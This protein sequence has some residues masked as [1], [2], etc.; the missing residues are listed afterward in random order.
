MGCNGLRD[1]VKQ[2]PGV[3]KEVNERRGQGA[4]VK[5]KSENNDNSVNPTWWL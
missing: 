5:Q 2:L 3:W 1:S 4:V